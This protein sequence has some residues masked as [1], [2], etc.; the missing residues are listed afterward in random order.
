MMCIMSP[1]MVVSGAWNGGCPPVASHGPWM[2]PVFS[3]GRGGGGVLSG[4]V[5]LFGLADDEQQISFHFK[6]MKVGNIHSPFDQ[7]LCVYTIG[8]PN[9]SQIIF[10]L[11]IYD[12]KKRSGMLL[13]VATENRIL[14]VV[15][16]NRIE[17]NILYLKMS[18]I[19][20][21]IYTIG[22]SMLFIRYA[23]ELH[24]KVIRFILVKRIVSTRASSE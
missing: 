2:R 14:E 20:T 6:S 4:G 7:N 8:E 12:V 15:K 5:L 3:V 1:R 23:H 21:A 24:N 16:N 10:I 22:G 17:I 11:Y 18:R 9:G 19:I 13:C